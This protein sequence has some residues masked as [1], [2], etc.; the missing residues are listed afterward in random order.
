MFSNIVCSNYDIIVLSESWLNCSVFDS[1]LFDDR[2]NVYRRDRE[3]GGFHHK[4]NGGGI[5]IAVKKSIKSYRMGGFE[6]KC[7]DVWVCVELAKNEGKQEILLICGVYLPPPIQKHILE[8]FIDNANRVYDIC[9]TTNKLIVGDFNLGNIAWENS[10]PACS[11]S[12]F[13]Q[14]ISDFVTF[15]SLKQ[16]NDV[17]NS[18]NRILD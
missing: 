5:L 15:N 13:N 14:M 18:G 10:Q 3:S 1:E 4:K 7:E 6:S 9:K 2:Y 12:L 16:H 8:H 11:N 17:L